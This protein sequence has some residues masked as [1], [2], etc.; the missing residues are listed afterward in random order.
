MTDMLMILGGWAILAVLFLASLHAGGF[1][2]LKILTWLERRLPIVAV[3]VGFASEK[4]F[5]NVMEP[6][7]SRAVVSG[8]SWVRKVF[9]GVASVALGVALLFMSI[10][11]IAELA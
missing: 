2:E 5:R 7:P 1:R 9:F 8:F 4:G 10:A 6:V 11:L 3:L